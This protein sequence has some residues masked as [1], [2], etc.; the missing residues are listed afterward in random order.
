MIDLRAQEQDRLQEVEEG[1]AAQA[2]LAAQVKSLADFEGPPEEFWP[3]YLE[4]ISR[5]AGAGAALLVVRAGDDGGWRSLSLWP[6]ERRSEIR[7]CGFAAKIDEIADQAHRQGTSWR[8]APEA[9]PLKTSLA[10]AID[11]DELTPPSVVMLFFSGK[12][13]QSVRPLIETAIAFAAAVPAAYQAGRRARQ[14]V[15]ETACQGEA[16]DLLALMND[17]D[18]F[19]ACA[20][21]FCNE[22]AARY[23]CERVSLGWVEDH[24]VRV[25]AVSHIEKFQEKMDA[26]QS[27]EAAMEECLDQ[28][29][30]IVLPPPADSDAVVREHENFLREQGGRYV[31]SLPLR[32]EGKATGV[33]FCERQEEPFTEDEIRALRIHCDLCARRICDLKDYDRWFGARF[34]SWARKHLSGLLGP[35][36]T[37]IKAVSV[38]VALALLFIV[39]GRLPYRVE[40]PFILKTDDL[41][42]LPAPFEGYID[43]VE[44]EVGDLV[45]KGDVLLSLD[46]KELLLEESTALANQNRYARE[47]EKARAQNALADMNIALALKKQATAQL[48]QVRYRLDHAVLRAPFAGVVVEGDLKELLG[49]P[50]RKG[51]V[52]F[53][54]ARLANLYAELE[55]DERDIH[56]VAAGDTGEIAFLSRPQLS[57]PVHVSRIEPVAVPKK[58][59]NVFQLRCDLED[60]PA[61]WWR[62][63]MSGVSKVDVGWRNV[64]WILTH[65]TIDFFRLLLWW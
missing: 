39:F 65:R 29:E 17:Q 47:A 52:L 3:R 32:I 51:D 14:V 19:V 6:T 4:G 41:A 15:M 25:Q 57:F 63:G 5:V 42:Y 28:D 9:G 18:R 53:K 7:D 40:A 38:L 21:T 58:D 43:K 59:G 62:P 55:V 24:Y 50:V 12:I 27:L 31:V 2:A 20:M 44:V 46:I 34:A 26:V 13:A 36:H 37:L 22:L 35:R 48:K 30:E 33:L 10:V 49:A 60:A 54:V 61:D 23:R 64:F 8:P 1:L 56:E 45:R 11:G 16:L